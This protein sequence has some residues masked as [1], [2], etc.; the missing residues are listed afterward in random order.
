M[1]ATNFVPVRIEKIAQVH[2]THVTFSSSGWLFYG[3]PTICN[4]DVVNS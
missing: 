1:E 2:S 3:G 4:R